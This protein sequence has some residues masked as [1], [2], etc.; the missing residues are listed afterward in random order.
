MKR[1]FLLLYVVLVSSLMSAQVTFQFS[2]G[3]YN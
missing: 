2:D 3:I 1:Y